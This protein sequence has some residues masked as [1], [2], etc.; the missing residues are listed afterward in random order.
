MVF[1]CQYIHERFACLFN[2]ERA[3]ASGNIFNIEK[4]KNTIN[5]K[6][7]SLAVQ[8]GFNIDVTSCAE[9]YF[10]KCNK[11]SHENI[12]HNWIM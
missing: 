9:L 12:G 4:L 8:Q 1:I 10:L 3:V 5:M 6:Y 7:S 11:K 2:R